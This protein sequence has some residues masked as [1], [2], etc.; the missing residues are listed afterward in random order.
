MR[1][2]NGAPSMEMQR[3]EK[4]I[5]NGPLWSGL[6]RVYYLPKLFR[7]AELHS[8]ESGLEL[9]CGQGV[10]TE[11]ILKRLPRLRLT[12]LDYDPAQVA[13]ARERVRRRS[14]HGTSLFK[15]CTGRACTWSAV[16]EAGGSSLCGRASLSMWRAK[17]Q[18]ANIV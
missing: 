6:L 5:V 2:K 8:R 1:T 15:T 7:L 9:G 14:S 16:L 4:W 18:G 13:R 12:A 3:F 11:E 10:T 17:A